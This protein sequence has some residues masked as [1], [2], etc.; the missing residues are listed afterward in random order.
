MIPWVEF[1][2]AA[3]SPSF[4][5]TA[6]LCTLGSNTPM[7]MVM[8]SSAIP[9]PLII[10]VASLS[11]LAPGITLDASA[12]KPPNIIEANC[13]DYAGNTA[14]LMVRSTP[15]R[16]TMYFKQDNEAISSTYPQT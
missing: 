4:T 16:P 1:T 3:T 9:T 10:S 5:D 11:T 14:G 2:S 7:L 13:G 15:T 8:L 6:T 12:T